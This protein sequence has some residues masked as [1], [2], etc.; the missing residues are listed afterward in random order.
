MKSFAYMLLIV[1]IAGCGINST[2]EDKAAET[3]SHKL[4]FDGFAGNRIVNGQKIKVSIKDSDGDV[5]EEGGFASLSVTLARKC[6]DDESYQDVETVDAVEGMAT[7]VIKDWQRDNKCDV[8]VTANGA[9]EAVQ[10]DLSVGAELLSLEM[11]NQ[12]P[13]MLHVKRAFT[14]KVKATSSDG[15]TFAKDSKLYLDGHNLKQFGQVEAQAKVD[16]NGVATFDNLYFIAPVTTDIELR[17]RNND[18]SEVGHIYLMSEI[19]LVPLTGKIGSAILNDKAKT[20]KLTGLA[21]APDTDAVEIGYAIRTRLHDDQYQIFCSGGATLGVGK[22]EV[23]VAKTTCL[24]EKFKE[25]S[26]LPVKFVDVLISID[27]QT[28]EVRSTPLLVSSP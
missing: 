16:D 5:A 2:E 22:D 6:G 8:R 25:A 13:N 21:P 7:F 20:L 3:D 17:I 12:L 19:L 24:E 15:R 26:E 27:G 14:L 10:E 28:K 9:S 18:R 23:T 1:F 11:K 4:V